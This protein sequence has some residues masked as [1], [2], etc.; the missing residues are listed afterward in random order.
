[1]TYIKAILT[2]TSTRNWV[3][4]L[5]F[6]LIFLFAFVISGVTR[7]AIWP[8]KKILFLTRNRRALSFGRHS[9]KFR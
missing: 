8:Q 7:S 5:F 1:M 3:A 2:Q 4:N 9:I 6:F